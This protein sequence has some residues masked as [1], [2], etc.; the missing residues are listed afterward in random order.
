MV[1][2]LRQASAGL[3]VQW[4]QTDGTHGL[5]LLFHS[6]QLQLVSCSFQKLPSPEGMEGR[7]EA[8]V[9]CTLATFAVTTSAWQ[10]E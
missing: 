1:D 2:E 10:D 4:H 8:A 6:S 9:A 5:A 3:H 7:Y